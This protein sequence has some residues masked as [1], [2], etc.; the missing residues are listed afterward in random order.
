MPSPITNPLSPDQHF[1]AIHSVAICTAMPRGNLV[2]VGAS[3]VKVGIIRIKM[4]EGGAG[5]RRAARSVKLDSPTSIRPS[6]R[7]DVKIS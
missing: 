4:G 1:P 6:A 7:G 2:I 5:E 3:L